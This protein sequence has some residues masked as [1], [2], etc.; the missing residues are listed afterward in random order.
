MNLKHSVNAL[1]CL[2][3]SIV[4]GICRLITAVR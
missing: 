3:V 2:G 1:M 4:I